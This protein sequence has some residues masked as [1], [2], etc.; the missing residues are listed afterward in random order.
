MFRIKLAR[1]RTFWK[2]QL[3]R[4]QRLS[5]IVTFFLILALPLIVLAVFIQTRLNP[6][7]TGGGYF[8]AIATI[9]GGVPAQ[10][11]ISKYIWGFNFMPGGVFSGQSIPSVDSFF[12][13]Y[14]EQKTKDMGIKVIRYTGGCDGDA[15]DSS[16]NKLYYRQVVGN[17]TPT[18]TITVKE[19]LSVGE[20]IQIADS[21][22]AEVMYQ[23][24]IT[25]NGETNI[26]GVTNLN[27]ATVAEAVQV[28]SQ[29]SDKITYYE[30]GNEQWGNWTPELYRDRVILFAQAMKAVNP[31]IKIG[32]QGWPANGNNQDPNAP[33]NPNAKAWRAMIN[34]LFAEQCSGVACFD[35]VTDHAYVWTGY[36]PR[37]ANAAPINFP[38]EAA[39]YPLADLDGADGL[40][41]QNKYTYN[42]KPIALTEWNL[43]C[44]GVAGT[45]ISLNNDSFENGT[46]GWS[47]WENHSNIGT[48]TSATNEH[49]HDD[50]SI[51]VS[52]N[53]DTSPYV[54]TLIQAAQIFPVTNTADAF[55]AYVW[56][57]VDK[58]AYGRFILQQTNAGE[59]QYHHLGES[60]LAVIQPNVWQ[61]VLVYGVPFTDTSQAQIVLR[62]DK[63][64]VNWQADQSGV[65]AYFDKVELV[66]GRKALPALS[67]VEHGMYVFETLL[68]MAKNN[69]FMGGI[70]DFSYSRSCGFQENKT[71]MIPQ[72][73]A[74]KLSSSIAGGTLLHT[75][76]VSPNFSIPLNEA[77]TSHVCLRGGE[78]IP[79]VSAYVG[80]AGGLT[81]PES[82]D[83]YVYLVNRHTTESADVTLN[84]TNMTG[85][86]RNKMKMTSLTASNYT[87]AI[88]QE[89]AEENINRTNTITVAPISIKR[90]KIYYEAPTPT[91]TRTPTPVLPIYKV[92]NSSVKYNGNLGGLTGADTKCQS[93]AGA[94]G[95][96]GTFKAWLSTSTVDA[97]DRI[98]DA[99]YVLVNGTLVANNKAD[100]IDGSIQNAIRIN[101][102]GNTVTNSYTWTG[103]LQNGT[104]HT[105]NCTNWTTSNSSYSGDRGHKDRVNTTWTNYGVASCNWYDISLY[106]FQTT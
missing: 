49:Y 61:E 59:H 70:H 27:D 36:N 20:S 98:P 1:F 69:L 81:P 23:V 29:H 62:L 19:V 74:Y 105:S 40:F 9:D 100:L 106:C 90:I 96:T 16:T 14:D 32:I 91:P 48:M 60:S 42:Q 11:P 101:E 64:V 18:P 21:I 84:F 47:Y 50:K 12:I 94:A 53:P 28:V 104:K 35:F 6:K 8:S 58:P 79:Y 37:A 39:Y 41:Q 57:K 51:K 46:S 7:A 88:F 78:D 95:L 38:G 102:F 33:P 66:Q 56:V 22:G 54:D 26:C 67:T 10:T 72:G 17:S 43:M 63:R 99:G 83:V 86:N 89:P 44:W 82:N 103:T 75:S 4:S 65:T 13:I 97:K 15:F 77:C 52:L 34:G 25:L 2:Y 92:F 45:S 24:N 87:D 30:M 80:Y 55:T 5:L 85:D 3:S 76:V 73:Q 31:A 71:T 68:L 93:R